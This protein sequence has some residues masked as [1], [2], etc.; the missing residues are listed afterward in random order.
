MTYTFDYE[1]SEDLV[2][3]ATGQFLRHHLHW[4]AKLASALFVFLVVMML[5]YDPGVTSGVLAGAGLLLFLLVAIA[6]RLRIQR[7]GA[8][9]RKLPHRHSKCVLDD[10]GVTVENALGNNRL[11]WRMLEKVVRGPDVWL[12]FYSRQH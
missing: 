12:M 7:G 2:R 5:V 4:R 9:L 6:Y 10:Q 8:L 3:Q 1:L 11:E